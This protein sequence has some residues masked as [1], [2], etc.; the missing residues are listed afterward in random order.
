[1]FLDLQGEDYGDEADLGL[2]HD[3]L[4]GPLF[5]FVAARNRMGRAGAGRRL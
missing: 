1:M 3:L 5:D 2:M 4:P